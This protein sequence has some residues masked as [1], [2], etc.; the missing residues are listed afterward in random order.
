MR[1]RRAVVA[2]TAS[3]AAQLLE[4][5]DPK[6]VTTQARPVI[7][8]SVV[9]MLPGGGAQYRDM[10][11]DLYECEPVYRQAVD[12]CCALVNPDFGQDLQAVLVPFN[13]S[14]REPGRDEWQ[15]REAP[16]PL[17]NLRPL[18]WAQLQQMA[19]RR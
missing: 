9:F 10:G 13:R 8:P 12:E 17:L 14:Q 15:V 1:W 3:E 5:G 4:S 19:D 11:R 6:R 18:R 7:A 16:F 2:A